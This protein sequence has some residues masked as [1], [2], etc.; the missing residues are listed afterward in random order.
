MSETNLEKAFSFNREIASLS[1]T[2]LPM[3]IGLQRGETLDTKLDQINSCLSIR[4]ESGETL[5]QAICNATELPDRYRA[6][7]WAWLHHPDPA[8]ALDRL[9]S[10]AQTKSDFGRYLGNALFYPLLLLCMAYLGLLSLCLYAGPALE[11]LFI[12]FFGSAEPIQWLQITQQSILIWAPIFPAIML[13]LLIGW[14]LLRRRSNWKWIPGSSR[15]YEAFANANLARQL[16]ILIEG[17]QSADEA[18]ALLDGHASAQGHQQVK[19]ENLPPLLR[20]AVSAD[21][22]AHS[23]TGVLHL[24]AESYRQIA[25]RQRSFWRVVMPTLSGAILGGIIVLAYGLAL[26]LPL[27]ELLYSVAN[28]EVN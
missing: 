23:L 10:P 4:V 12:S 8:I 9:S 13:A 6:S 11:S 14:Y 20:W 7:L 27:I 24:A 15:Y 22:G 1:A 5:D 16:A 19:I 3:D 2:G 28:G 25:E 21:L 18:L 26:F 17:G